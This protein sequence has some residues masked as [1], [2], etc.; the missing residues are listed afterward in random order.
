MEA[1]QSGHLLLITK[2]SS[3]P[4]S[5]LPASTHLDHLLDLNNL[6]LGL[7]EP[8]SGDDRQDDPIDDLTHLPQLLHPL[9][10]QMA[11]QV[12]TIEYLQRQKR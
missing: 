4:E 10:L 7:E 12:L 8:P 3:P 11:L 9:T 6:L 5:L 1:F 2:L